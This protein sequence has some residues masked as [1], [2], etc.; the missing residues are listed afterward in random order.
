MHPAA[1]LLL[2]RET[3]RDIKISGY[4]VPAKTRIYVNAWAIGRDLISWSNDPDEFNPD[5][6]E[7]N[8]IDIKGEHPELMP[9]GAGRRIC[10]GISMAMATIE[11]TLA[12]LLFSFEWALP[13]GTTIHDVNMEEEGRLILHRKEPLVLVPTSYHLDL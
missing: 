9:F 5:R 3:M 7:V 8:D 10:P 1:P 2:P 13:E 11:F 4:D 12:N 6:F